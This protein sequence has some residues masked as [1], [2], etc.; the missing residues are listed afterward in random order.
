M[1]EGMRP[2]VTAIGFFAGFIILSYVVIL[3]A[4][5]QLI[6]GQSVPEVLF[7]IIV[8][9]TGESVLSPT[10]PAGFAA[11]L[12]VIAFGIMV[13][14][15]VLEQLGSAVLESRLK[16]LMSARTGVP[17]TI[18]RHVVVCGDTALASMVMHEVKAMGHDA[19]LVDEVEDDRA[20]EVVDEGFHVVSG[21]PSDE[22]V[23]LAA[24]VDTAHAVVAASDDDGAN[25]FICLSARDLN[26]KVRIC[27]AMSNETRHGR[28][29]RAGADLAISPE[30]ITGRLLAQCG[31][32][33]LSTSFTLEL[34]DP[35][36][37]LDIDDIQ[38]PSKWDGHTVR[39]IMER[40]GC[41]LVA[42][43]P[44]DAEEITRNPPSD[45]TVNEGDIMVIIGR[46]EDL[47]TL[48]SM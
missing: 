8:S 17:P 23:L 19:V 40:T 4:E 29:K 38:V 18:E 14:M 46:S 42:H 26:E 13:V 37:G 31:T 1:R 48:R 10:T 9:A 15:F 20:R 47:A 11:T 3:F 39:A 7:R 21:N 2:Y 41:L 12:L 32:H 6:E 45:T 24:R 36:V 27:A 16:E 33:P 22:D 44:K 35:E 34:L 28:F 25:S 5:P 30:S 43:F